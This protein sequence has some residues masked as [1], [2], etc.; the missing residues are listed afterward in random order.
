MRRDG[1]RARPGTI[2][3]NKVA[4]VAL[5]T[6]VSIAD[7]CTTDILGPRCTAALFEQAFGLVG[8]PSCQDT[9]R[10]AI[11]EYGLTPA[12]VHDSFILLMDTT[13]DD[14]GWST[15]RDT[16]QVGD[17]IELLALR[18]VLAL[19]VVCGSGNVFL[20][21]NYG[22]KPNRATQGGGAADGA[23][24]SVPTAATAIPAA[25]AGADPLLDAPGT[26]S[27]SHGLRVGPIAGWSDEPVANSV[28]LCLPTM[29]AP[30]ARSRRTTAAFR[31]G[32]R[33]ARIV[34]PAVVRN[35]AVSMTSLSPMGTPRSGPRYRPAR[36]SRSATRAARRVASTSMMRYAPMSGSRR[37]MRTRT[38]SAS[39][40]AVYRP[41]RRS[42]AIDRIE[43]TRTLSI[44]GARVSTLRY[45]VFIR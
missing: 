25:T 17:R 38:A 37:S 2:L 36:S 31:R 21:S 29:T 35:A 20:T 5:I 42:P 40:S 8:Q 1:F 23:D 10:E 26:R 16:G 44:I 34:E 6:V 12:D 45:R 15:T 13:V 14:I 19:P 27:G 33:S 30:A 22:Y 11:R 7:S 41:A 3:W 39:R 4:N 43:P 18:D 28:I 32:A 24:V 9:L